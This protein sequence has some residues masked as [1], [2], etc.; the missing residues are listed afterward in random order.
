MITDGEKQLIVTKVD[1][2][3]QG[4]TPNSDEIQVTNTA[5]ETED[6]FPGIIKL[7]LVYKFFII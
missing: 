2:E 1:G 4:Q 3:N 7:S 6:Y 5:E